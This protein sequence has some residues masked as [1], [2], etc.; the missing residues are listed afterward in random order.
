MKLQRIARWNVLLSGIG[1]SPLNAYISGHQL[2]HHRCLDLGKRQ[3]ME[4]PDTLFGDLVDYIIEIEARCILA[5]FFIE[6]V[7][8]LSTSIITTLPLPPL[9]YTSFFLNE[10]PH[11][12]DL[13]AGL[14]ERSIESQYPIPNLP[15]ELRQPMIPITSY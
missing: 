13:R 15:K 1:R 11:K 6:T 9:R 4:I 7:S 12:L 3:E 10:L 5:I 14:N 8:T 2:A